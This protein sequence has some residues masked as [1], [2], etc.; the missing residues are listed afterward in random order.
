VRAPTPIAIENRRSEPFGWV[1]S[2]AWLPSVAVR[3]TVFPELVSGRQRDALLFETVA[4][5]VD[6]NERMTMLQT[7]N[8]VEPRDFA[9]ARRL[10]SPGLIASTDGQRTRDSIVL[11]HSIMAR[12][13]LRRL[14]RIRGRLVP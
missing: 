14:G 11:V 9:A 6:A 1:V 3:A 12:R 2:P 4:D 5:T 8:R 7:D 10:S 13:R